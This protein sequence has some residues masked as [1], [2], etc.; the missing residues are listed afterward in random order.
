MKIIIEICSVLKYIFVV[1]TI[2]SLFK[3]ENKS[4]KQL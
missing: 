1:R 4:A 2:L 3:R